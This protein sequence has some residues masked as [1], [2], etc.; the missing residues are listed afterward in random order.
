MFHI[1]VML[2]MAN[3]KLIF[4]VVICGFAVFGLVI[5]LPMLIFSGLFIY[6][7]PVDISAPNAY[8][9]VV[10]LGVSAPDLGSLHLMQMKFK[11]ESLS[12]HELFIGIAPQSQVERFVTNVPHVMITSIGSDSTDTNYGDW[13]DDFDVEFIAGTQPL[14]MTSPPFWIE[15]DI[16]RFPIMTWYPEAGQYMLV[17]MNTDYSQGMELQYRQGMK[18]EIL[19]PIGLAFLFISLF[20]ILISGLLIYAGRSA[21][22][23]VK[24]TQPPSVPVSPSSS[25]DS[26]VYG[27]PSSKIHES[28]LFCP[29]CGYHLPAVIGD[30]NFCPKCGG[31]LN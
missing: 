20:G 12:M 15:D 29:S 22:K 28:A 14:N 18:I 19:R 16:G 5:S 4:G 8:A 26:S 30:S 27:A 24:A 13:R 11:G 3:L 7:S 10:S 31:K 6:D 21:G 17:I 9:V 23:K 2:S 1:G 25:P